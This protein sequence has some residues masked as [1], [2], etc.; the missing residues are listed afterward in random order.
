MGEYF[1]Q[2]S[3]LQNYTT[4][5]KDGFDEDFECSVFGSCRCPPDHFDTPCSVLASP[6][7]ALCRRN[8]AAYDKFCN[9][10]RRLTEVELGVINRVLGTDKRIVGDT[11]KRFD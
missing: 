2:N 1:E 4:D 9:A 3:P 5:Y 8:P 7:M 10:G 6:R 11:I